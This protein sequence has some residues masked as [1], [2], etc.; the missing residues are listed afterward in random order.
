MN[1]DIDE[2]KKAQQFLKSWKVA[3]KKLGPELFTVKA[4]NV[5]VATDRNDIRPN[6]EAIE[7]YIN[8]NPNH[9]YFLFLVVS[10]FSYSMIEDM[11]AEAGIGFPR[12]VDYQFLDETE[13]MIIYSLIENFEDW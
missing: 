8:N 1:S 5:D 4:A 7:Q 9:H 12:I 13:R 11:F 2:E 3:A 6:P 10:F